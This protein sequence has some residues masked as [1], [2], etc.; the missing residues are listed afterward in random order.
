VSGE[1][2]ID[3]LQDVEVTEMLVESAKL[4]HVFGHV[5]ALIPR[6]RR[7]T[8]RVSGSVISR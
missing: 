4:D 7:F 2:E 1:G 3:S 8:T 6:S 5:A